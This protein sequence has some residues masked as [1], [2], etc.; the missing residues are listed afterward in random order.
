MGSETNIAERWLTASLKY[1]ET[2]TP[3]HQV[4]L[5][6]P[7]PEWLDKHYPNMPVPLDRCTQEEVAVLS[8]LVEQSRGDPELLKFIKQADEDMLVLFQQKW[9]QLFS[10]AEFPREELQSRLDD[11]SVFIIKMKYHFNRARPYQMAEHFGLDF[12][13]LETVSAHSPS[14]PSGHAIQAH[15]IGEALSRLAPAHREEFEDLA[16]RIAWSRAQAGY[17]FPSDLQYGAAIADV[18]MADDPPFIR[19]AKM[20]DLDPQLGWPGGRCHVV[21]RILRTVRDPRERER[22]ISEVELGLHIDNQEADTI[23]DLEVERGAG[24]FKKIVLSQHAQYR[25][26]ERNV[27]LN[28]VRLTLADFS[29]EYQ[30]GLEMLKKQNV[31]K[32]RLLK[33]RNQALRWQEEMTWGRRP[34]VYTSD[35][36]LTVVFTAK[37]KEN[38]AKIVTAYWEGLPDPKP[39]GEG[40]CERVATRWMEAATPPPHIEFE[41]FDLI[42][43]RPN[44]AAYDGDEVIAG[45]DIRMVG[46]MSETAAWGKYRCAD[47]IEQLAALMEK[48]GERPY[49]VYAV[50]ES[51]LEEEYHGQGI[52]RGLYEYA[53][54]ELSDEPM[55]LVPDYC[56][57]GATSAQAKRVWKSLGRDYLSVGDVISS[58]R[59]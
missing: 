9:W 52:G 46:H 42:S 3:K 27:V 1:R 18:I 29:K 53:L 7:T 33:L 49:Y 12:E 57:G 26:D 13:P 23:Y 2:P 14:Y 10:D 28:D 40:S 30:R 38:V 21:D 31:R 43:S 4:M 50:S 45:L 24:M 22:L 51:F 8:R 55:I 54:R 32:P 11:L 39:V 16:W 48:K 36:G 25:M 17:H 15:A 47:D 34:L 59:K 58:L 37:P 41:G 19:D 6:Q 35:F 5:D 20:A 44:F 56:T